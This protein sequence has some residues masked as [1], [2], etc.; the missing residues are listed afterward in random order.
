MDFYS[1]LKKTLICTKKKEELN[2]KKNQIP[3]FL[4]IETRKAITL[5]DKMACR[6]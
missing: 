5:H 6:I 3:T 2:Y 4:K 1:S